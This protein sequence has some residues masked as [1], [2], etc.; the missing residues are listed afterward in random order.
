MRWVLVLGAV[1]LAGSA[2][3]QD[4]AQI[5]REGVARIGDY[6]TCMGQA[7]RHFVSKPDDTDSAMFLATVA[8]EACDKQ[9]KAYEAVVRRRHAAPAAAK[10]ALSAATAKTRQDFADYVEQLRREAGRPSK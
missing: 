5:D 4:A 6:A 9:W 7:A 10:Q 3:A 2:G 1:L 8:E